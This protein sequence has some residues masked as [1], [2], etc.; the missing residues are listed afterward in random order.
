MKTIKN[1]KETAFKI[2]W[3]VV[4]NEGVTVAKFCKKETAEDFKENSYFGY[5]NDC[6]I[7]F[8]SK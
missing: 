1:Y 2:G 3:A 5:Y 7:K 8:I 6:K 4:T